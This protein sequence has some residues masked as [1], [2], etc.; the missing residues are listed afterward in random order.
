MPIV[1]PHFAPEWLPSI[2]DLNLIE[3][4]ISQGNMLP[5]YSLTRSFLQDLPDIVAKAVN[6]ADSETLTASEV[7]V[8]PQ[9]MHP[10]TN[11][12]GWWIDL[13]PSDVDCTWTERRS[14]RWEIQRL[15]WTG[16]NNWLNINADEER[17]LFDVECRPIDSSGTSTNEL[18]V[19]THEWGKPTGAASMIGRRI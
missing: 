1:I 8:L 4:Y 17:P 12:Y 2:A 15:V 6:E 16:V 14:R 18:G 7:L 3:S 10:W 13:S 11:A 19:V 5:K 9:V